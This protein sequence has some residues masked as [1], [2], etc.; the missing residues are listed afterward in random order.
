MTRRDHLCLCRLPRLIPGL[1]ILLLTWGGIAPAGA[2]TILTRDTRI[3]ARHS[4]Q[5]DVL[6]RADDHGRSPT[7]T[8][9]AGGSI[10]GCLTADARSTIRLCGGAIGGHLIARDSSSIDFSSGSVVLSLFANDQSTVRV[11]DGSIGHD[12]R[13]LDRST[14]TVTGGAIGA[15][16]QA[17][18]GSRIT[19]SGGTIGADLFA[20]GHSTLTLSGG[21]IEGHLFADRRCTLRFPGG[22]LRPV[23]PKPVAIGAF[24]CTRYSVS[25]TPPRPTVAALLAGV[26]P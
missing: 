5:D 19:I 9:A 17:L 18:P 1:V 16:M 7:I 22:A 12:L 6:V 10:A 24:H 11:S 20:F 21:A 8:I 3:D 13:A 26:R 15:D 23:D 2:L 14:V 4:I 25:V